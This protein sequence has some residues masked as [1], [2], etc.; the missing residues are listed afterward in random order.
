MATNPMQRKTRNAFIL[1]M[2]LTLVIAAAIIALLYMKIQNQKKEL[3]QYVQ[4]MTSV[5]VLNRDVKSGQALTLDMFS[6]KQVAKSTVPSDATEDV[7]TMIANAKLVD[8]AG[9]TI[10]VP[11]GEKNYYYYKFAGINNDIVIYTG[12]DEPVTSLSAGDKAYYYANGDKN[13]QKLE[14]EIAKIDSVV[15]KTDMKANTIITRN[16]IT[17]A[18]E[19]TTD[20]LRKEEY[21]V[22]SLPVDLQPGEYVDIRLVLPNGQNYIVVSKKKVDIPVSN[23]AYLPD[24]IQMN[25]TED[26]ILTLS[27]AIVEN[28][29][30]SG[31]KLY[32]ARYVEAGLQHASVETYQP[33]DYVITLVKTDKNVVNDA[34]KRLNKRNLIDINS[35]VS[36]YGK[37]ENIETKVEESL[38]T[39]IEA[40]KNYLQT[41]VP[42]P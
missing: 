34:I 21:N 37:E 36:N 18:E 39:T 16:A 32:A 11:N 7:N 26:E 3:D 29:Q 9:R 6:K 12:N 33:N 1:G 24:T 22:I 15:A 23:G 40:R 5:Y 10:N 8:T 30:M 20:D 42:T 13:S 27:C 14:T 35:A 41:L 25:L 19:R 17:L 31:S 28:F 38:T 4:S 2:L